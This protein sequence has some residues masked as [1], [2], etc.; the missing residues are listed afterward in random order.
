MPVPNA[1]PFVRRYE[2]GGRA[3]QDGG[4]DRCRDVHVEATEESP[5]GEEGVTGSPNARP[6]G[7]I[8]HH[9]PPRLPADDQAAGCPL[10]A[11]GRHGHPHASRGVLTVTDSESKIPSARRA[12]E[13]AGGAEEV[14][15]SLRVKAYGHVV[16]LSR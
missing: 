13:N 16:T 9:R 8:F 2:A 1:P 14:T 12:S 10:A 3:R 15:R 6:S 5:P 11:T 7:A 4:D